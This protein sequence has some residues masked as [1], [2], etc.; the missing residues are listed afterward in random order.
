M[1]T[2]ADHIS[3]PLKTSDYSYEEHYK[4]F[5]NLHMGITTK[6]INR[7]LKNLSPDIEWGTK[8]NFFKK[9]KGKDELRKYFENFLLNTKEYTAKIKLTCWDPLLNQGNVWIE[10]RHMDMNFP[11]LQK[12]VH[13][14]GLFQIEDGLISD[15][16]SMEKIMWQR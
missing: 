2:Q 6:D 3:G 11:G 5:D 7:I 9:I 8:D 15:Y 14:F 12:H 10:H 13:E 4:L 16:L 1:K